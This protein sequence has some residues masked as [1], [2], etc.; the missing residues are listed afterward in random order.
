M[1][2][3][4]LSEIPSRVQDPTGKKRKPITYEVNER[5]CFICTSHCRSPRGYPLIR[6]RSARGGWKCTNL[7]RLVHEAAVGPIPAG[8]IIRHKCDEPRCINPAHLLLGTHADNA[9]DKVERGRQGRGESFG[10]SK[11]TDAQVLEIRSSGASAER[12]AEKFSVCRATI[13]HARRGYTW[14]HVA[15]AGGQP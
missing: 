7:S 11:L 1:S 15:A 10:M 13:Y 14:K 5:G 6:V 9:R 2:E 12:L 4:T 8:Q 3:T